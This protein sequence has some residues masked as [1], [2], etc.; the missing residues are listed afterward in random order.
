MPKAAKNSKSAPADNG[1]ENITDDSEQKMP[2]AS[3]PYAF[4]ADAK[5]DKLNIGDYSLEQDELFIVGDSE[6]DDKGL[7]HHHVSSAND[8]YTNG[9]PQII[10]QVF[11]VDKDIINQ[12]DSTAEDKLIERIHVIIKFTNVFIIFGFNIS[13]FIY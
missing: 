8:L 7:V 9:I 2:V 10:T 1:G 4:D 12:R 3:D 5:K 13:K 6:I 11:E